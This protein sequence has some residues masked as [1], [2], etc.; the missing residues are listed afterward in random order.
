M[1]LR[2]LPAVFTAA[3]LLAGCADFGEPI[4]GHKRL[5]PTE[6]RLQAAETKLADVSKRL[7][8]FNQVFEDNGGGRLS[9]DLRSLRGDV[10]KLRFDLDSMEKRNRD[11][12]QDLDRRLQ[13]LE[14]TAPATGSPSPAASPSTSIGASS[15]SPPAEPPSAAPQEEAAYLQAFDQLKGGKYDDAISGFKAMIQKWP[16][17]RYADNAWY[18]MG[19]A[20]YVKRDYPAAVQSFQTV[21]ERFPKSPKAPDALLKLGLAQSESKQKDQSRATLQR[22]IKDYPSSNAASL[23]RQRLAQP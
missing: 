21:A 22:L 8:A 18:W 6:V 12:Y 2:V 20:H 9:D 5:S 3:L 10:E 1:R 11:L 13:R 16:D 4:D 19:E 15:Q 17:G 23:A 14:G 7:D